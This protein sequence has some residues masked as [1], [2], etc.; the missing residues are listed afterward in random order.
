MVLAGADLDAFLAAIE[1][2]PNPAPR[3]VKALKRH[4]RLFG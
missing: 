2:K 4:R 3:L 1:R